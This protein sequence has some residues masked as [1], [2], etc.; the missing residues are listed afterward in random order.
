MKRDIWVFLFCLGALLF[1]AP[2][3]SIFQDSLVY[4]LFVIWFCFI[5]LIFLAATF[6]NREDGGN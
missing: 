3:L 2:F 1:G 6:S 5:G 4:Y